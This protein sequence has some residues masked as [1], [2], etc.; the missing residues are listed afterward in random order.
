MDAETIFIVFLVFFFIFGVPTITALVLGYKWINARH[1]ER[2]GLIN[3]GLIPE[4]TARLKKP[5]PN[6]LVSLRNGIVLAFLG[7]G[8]V[9]GN[10]LVNISATGTIEIMEGHHFNMQI[11]GLL[12]VAS[13]VFFLGL[14]YLTYFF[15]SRKIEKEEE[16]NENDFPP[17][18]Q[19]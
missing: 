19:Q 9:V 6:R 8:I 15:I 2:I 14:G 17:F 11:G 7:I 12:S 10:F 5:N 3:Q 13:I 16:E 1:T 18:Q 4:N